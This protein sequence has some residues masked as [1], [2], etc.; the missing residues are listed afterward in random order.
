[1][2]AFILS[3]NN[4]DD[5]PGMLTRAL[6]ARGVDAVGVAY[7]QPIAGNNVDHVLQRMRPPTLSGLVAELQLA[8]VLH[9]FD[10]PF[11]FGDFELDAHL[12][13][14]NALLTYR[15]QHFESAAPTAFFRH[16]RRDIVATVMQCNPHQGHTPLPALH[17]PPVIDLDEVAPAER[18]L[19]ALPVVAVASVVGGRGTGAVAHTALA[20]IRGRRA[21]SLAWMEGLSR[22]DAMRELGRTDIL[23]D[24]LAHPGPSPLGFAA[25][26]L[27]IAVVTNI[28]GLDRALYP[29]LP[30]VPAT[31]PNLG[32]VLEG[33]LGEPDRL[34][35]VS[36]RGR[37][38][39]DAH[40]A[41]D[42]VVDRWLALYR[43]VATAAAWCADA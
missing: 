40:L 42:V 22:P 27:G 23:V 28:S 33:L 30:V 31:P 32:E 26:A 3:P 11:T 37:A 36:R 43:H 35:A 29:G 15:G 39:A 34:A 24:D 12:R 21:L 38:W 18:P 2:K 4:A 16:F 20:A 10:H 8:D 19:R 41:T 14:D 13:Y 17:L 9:V 25:M 5:V 1:M 6:A 7:D